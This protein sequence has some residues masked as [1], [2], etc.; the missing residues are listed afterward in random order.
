MP[1]ARRIRRDWA[2]LSDEALLDVRLCDLDVRVDDGTL[3]AN[4]ERLRR[5]LAQAGLRFRPYAWLSTDWFTPDGITG[6]GI[7]F[8]LAHPRLA[9]LERKK[10]FEVEGGDRS[11]CMRLLRHETAHAL[12][13]AYR[14]RRRKAWREHF[15]RAS[16]PYHWSYVPNPDSRKYVINLDNWYAQSHPA[17]DFAETFAVWLRPG[18]RWRHRY[19]SWPV[20]LRKL[21]FVDALMQEIRDVD[22]PVRTRERPDSLS[23]IRFTLREYYERKQSSYGDGDLSVYDRDLRRLFSGEPVRGGRRLA[24]AVLRRHRRPLRERVAQWTGQDAFVVDEVLKGLIVRARELQLHPSRP[25]Q[26]IVQDA[27]IVLTVHTM[28]YTRRRHREYFR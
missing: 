6:F 22:P 24:S 7:P 15:G 3:G 25:E 4:L 18:G 17:E 1:R 21:R 5:E 27:A 28:R 12:D 11:W 2:T 8:F 9:R 26:E 13:N 16:E 23:K 19:A 10:M 14:L 20:A